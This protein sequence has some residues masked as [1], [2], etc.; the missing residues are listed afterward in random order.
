MPTQSFGRMTIL[1]AEL[2]NGETHTMA[3][4]T[5][6]CPHCG[7]T[8]YRVAGHHFKMLRDMMIEAL[9]LLPDA[10]AETTKVVRRDHVSFDAKRGGDP[11]NN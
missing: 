1:S 2:P 7:P 11:T 8:V 6:D 4:I 3:E 9:D 10:D 5:I